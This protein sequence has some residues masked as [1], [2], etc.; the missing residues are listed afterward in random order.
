MQSHKAID[1]LY[2]VESEKTSIGM[3]I[4]GFDGLRRIN[5]CV[6]RERDYSLAPILYFGGLVKYFLAYNGKRINVPLTRY[7]A[8]TLLFETKGA[9]KGLSIMV[10]DDKGKFI[11]EIGRP[12]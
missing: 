10:F 3:A 4:K 7:E 5:L 2:K 8:M 11:R 6:I 12:R 1:A 9:I